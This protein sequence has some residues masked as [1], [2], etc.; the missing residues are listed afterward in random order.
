MSRRPRRGRADPPGHG[1][2]ELLRAILKAEKSLRGYV[3][4]ARG[5]EEPREPKQADQVLAALA[6]RYRPGDAIGLQQ[7]LDVIDVTWE[8][9]RAV[10]AWAQSQGAWP[11]LRPSPMRPAGRRDPAPAGR[12]RRKDGAR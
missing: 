12:R 9:A 11:Y 5:V 3:P 7:V 10:R 6:G 1:H 8:T 4:T 2:G